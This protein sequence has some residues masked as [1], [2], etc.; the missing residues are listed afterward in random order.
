M[1]GLAIIKILDK[2]LQH[3]VDKIYSYTNTAI[4][5]IVND[6][7]ETII[8]KPEGMIGI[9]DLR[10]LSYYKIISRHTASKS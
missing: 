9:V 7:T 8:F 10:S 2:Y 4:L 1:S 6:D 5:A 3:H